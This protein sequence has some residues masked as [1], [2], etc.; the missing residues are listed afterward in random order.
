[1]SIR[2]EA[3]ALHG[4]GFNCA[5]CVFGA[6]GKYSGLDRKTALAVAGGFGGGV[7]CGEICGAISGAVMA[8]GAAAPFSDASDRD[9]MTRIAALT[10]QCTG[11]FREQFGALRCLELKRAGVPCGDLIAFGAETAEKLICEI[12]KGE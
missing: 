11:A 9:A 12:K 2:D 3:T 5:Q 10:K 4:D 7:R 1:L 8:I 6:C